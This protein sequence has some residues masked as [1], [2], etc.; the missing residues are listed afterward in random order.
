VEAKKTLTVANLETKV[1]G[2]ILVGAKGLFRDAASGILNKGPWPMKSGQGTQFTIHWVIVNYATDVSNVSLKTFLGG[3]IKLIGTPKSTIQSVPIYNE[4]TQEL[5]W[6]IP[7]IVAT[8]GIVGTPVEA[9][10][11]VEALPSVANVGDDMT[12]IGKTEL[13]ATDDFTGE[14]LTAEDIEVT[15]DKLDD[16]TVTSLEGTV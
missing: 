14:S 9:I 8:K 6:D 15:T 1:G 7:D 10:F 12:L 13:R 11:Q 5:R 2:S 4:N 3:N 16:P